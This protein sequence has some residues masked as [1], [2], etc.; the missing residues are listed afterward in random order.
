MRRSKEVLRNNLLLRRYH[1][2][3]PF[4]AGGIQGQQEIYEPC[5]LE[6]EP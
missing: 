4:I 2:T 3:I 5:M 1:L 6:H